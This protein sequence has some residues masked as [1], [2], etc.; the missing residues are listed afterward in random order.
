MVFLWIITTNYF[1]LDAVDVFKS[2]CSQTWIFYVTL[3]NKVELLVNIYW[4]LS[5]IISIIG[6][7][8]TL[9]MNI[10]YWFL[11]S[12][13]YKL[14][15]N[16]TVIEIKKYVAEKSLIFLW[17]GLKY[18]VQYILNGASAIQWRFL[19]VPFLTLAFFFTFFFCTILSLIDWCTMMLLIMEIFRLPHLEE[20]R[21]GIPLIR[22][23]LR[24]R[25]CG[26]RVAS[27]H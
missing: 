9:T 17:Y 26:E 13:L 3:F 11:L 22:A 16:R 4:L 7:Q 14:Y 1:A 5:G 15:E 10:A 24:W 21:V 19:C 18:G 2:M 8:C 6:R 20:G 23:S 27:R 12:L 25:K